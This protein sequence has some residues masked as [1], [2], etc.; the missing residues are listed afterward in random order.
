MANAQWN[1]PCGA[2][3]WTYEPVGESRRVFIV[4]KYTTLSRIIGEIGG[5]GGGGGGEGVRGEGVV[6]LLL[7]TYRH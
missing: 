7:S 2:L 4:S 5:G 3:G 6:V 1:A